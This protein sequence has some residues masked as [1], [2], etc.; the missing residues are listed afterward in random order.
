MT[1]EHQTMISA[2]D[3]S[4]YYGSFPAV[5]DVS[6]TVPQCQVCAFLGPNGAGK[7]TTMK[8]L[9][10]FLAPTSGSVEIAGI[11]MAHGRLRA[12]ERIG[13]LPE[14]GPLYDEMT[15]RSALNYLGC[16]RG[17]SLEQRK[18]RMNYVAQTCALE[19]VWNKTIGKLSKGFRQRVGMAQA[20]LHDPD[21][22]ILDEPTS[23]LDPNQLV[24]IRELIIELGQTKT[25][26]LSTHVLQEVENL[27]Q[28]V[29][30]IDDGQIVCDR[31]TKEMGD[32]PSLE[33]EFHKLT[34]FTV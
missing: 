17:L 30:L 31:P 29:I 20:L 9:T 28:R 32:L 4:K 22:L 13:Y 15:P 18:N 5:R 7:S 19:E 14:N 2:K 8:L 24:G 10:G 6:F 23:G 25:V 1:P 26:L 33:N 11:D 34:N 12:S 16:A 27:C 3:L 21:V